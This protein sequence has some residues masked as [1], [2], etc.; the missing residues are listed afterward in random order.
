MKNFS[1]ILNR[2]LLTFTLLMMGAIMLAQPVIRV[3]P[4]CN[5]V[6]AGNGLGAVTGFG[7]QVGEG[8]VV[9]MPDPFDIIGGAGNFNYIANGTT[10]NSW[11][12]KGD[13]SVQTGTTSGAP[14]Q[15]AGALT[16]LN[17]QSYNKNL[18]FAENATPSLARSKG[19]VTVFYA[20]GACKTFITFEIFKNY[21]TPLPGIVGP[22]CLLPNTT[23]TYSVDQIASDNA[24]DAIGFDSYYWSGIPASFTNVYTSADQSSITFSTPAT[25][26]APFTIKCCYGRCNPFDGDAG[27]TPTSC[28]SKSIYAQP[29]APTF[30]TP[31]PSCLN[32]GLSSFTVVYTIPTIAPPTYTW[33]APGTTWNLNTSTSG[34]TQTLTVTG[35]DNNPGTL[36]LN[37]S[38]GVCL[39]TTL[40]YTINRSFVTPLA[41]TGPTCVSAGGTYSYSLPANALLNN[42]TIGSIPSGWT[43]TATNG[44]GS[45]FNVTVPANTLAGAYNMKVISTNCPSTFVTLT[46]NVKPN[47]PVFTTSSPTCVLKGTTAIS[48]IAVDTSVPGTPTTGYIWNLTLAPGWS[49]FSGAGTSTPT[50]IPNGTTA[51]PVTISVLLAGTNGCLSNAATHVVTYIAVV[52]SFN[53]STSFCD[54]YNISCGTVSSWEINGVTVT[55]STPN[56]SISGNLLSICGNSGPVSSV[57]AN[58][59]GV[60]GLVCATSVG[61][62]GLKQA[63]SSFN[64]GPRIEGVTISPNPNTGTFSILVDNFKVSASATLLDMTGK[65]I[66]VYTLQKGDNK[67]EREGLAKGTYFISLLID[68]QTDTRKIIIK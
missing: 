43:V 18:R 47:A 26:V 16:S 42:T 45:T 3:P 19:R 32:T 65:E 58:V 50:F 17:I 49:I 7:G 67:I 48:T 38:N 20:S 64:Q 39:P 4:T 30:T 11:G 61:T 21:N 24:L 5:V 46:I 34:S 68:S 62:H 57:C 60:S 36:A 9:C 40:A 37:I 29:V 22:D 63:Q 53:S 54:Q 59:V 8:G 2:K 13:I 66:G 10:L 25:P 28:V 31:V 27:A 23:Y 41:I 51:G 52:T 14:I 56:T 44:T 15:T 35:V 55:A 6:I 1:T 33:T 12:L